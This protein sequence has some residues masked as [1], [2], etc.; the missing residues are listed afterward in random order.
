MPIVKRRVG[1]VDE[2]AAVIHLRLSA[3]AVLE[4]RF[5]LVGCRTFMPEWALLLRLREEG[6]S[7][8]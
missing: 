7:K 2:I 3:V 5:A 1:G 8:R 6:T 4:G